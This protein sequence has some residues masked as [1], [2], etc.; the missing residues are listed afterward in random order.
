VGLAVALCVNIMLQVQRAYVA[1]RRIHD[2]SLSSLLRAPMR[3][4]DTTPVGR[5]LNRFSRVS[6]ELQ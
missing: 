1:A 3:F 6:R 4:F 2:R 5:V